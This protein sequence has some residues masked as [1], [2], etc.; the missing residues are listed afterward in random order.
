MPTRG[1]KSLPPAVRYTKKL[2]LVFNTAALRLLGSTPG[3]G[4]AVTVYADPETRQIGL[5]A[6]KEGQ[7]VVSKN[8]MSKGITRLALALC[9]ELPDKTLITVS[10]DCPA[11]EDGRKLTCVLNLPRR[12]Q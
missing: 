11:T 7:S 4:V 9:P 2:G 3:Q 10:V 1:Q 6:G 12:K 8:G 5:L